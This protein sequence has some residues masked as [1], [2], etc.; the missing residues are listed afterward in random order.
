MSYY[1]LYHFMRREWQ[2]QLILAKEH[3]RIPL[4]DVQTKL[5]MYIKGFT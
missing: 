2:S 1:K 4:M 3:L 5:L